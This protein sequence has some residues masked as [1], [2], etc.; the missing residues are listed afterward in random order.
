MNTTPHK[1]A[2]E[3]Q[4]GNQRVPLKPIAQVAPERARE[5]VELVTRRIREVEERQKSPA[6]SHQILLLAMLD[7]ANEYLDARDRATAHGQQLS[8]QA[9]ELL[10]IVN[11]QL[12]NGQA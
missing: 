12:P 7:L 2:F 6:A 10:R 4:I 1:D 8:A 5:V 3:I 9:D 11:E